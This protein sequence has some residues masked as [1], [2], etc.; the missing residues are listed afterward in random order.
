MTPRRPAVLTAIVTPFTGEGAID[1]PVFDQLLTMQSKGGVSGI[2]VAGT[3]GESPT[4]SVQEKLSLVRRA[5]ANLPSSVQVMAGSGGSS[6]EQSYE[7]SKLCLEAGADSL[8][9][10]T[11]PYNKPSVAGLLAHFGKIN[12]LGAPVCLYHVPGRTAQE[13][14]PAQLSSLCQLPNITMIKEAS[15]DLGLFSRAVASCDASLFSGDD[16]TY[17]PSLAVGGKGV[18]SVVSNIFPQAMVALGQAFVDGDSARSQRINHILLPFMDMM[19]CESNPGP[20]KAVLASRFGFHN[21]LRLPLVAVSSENQEPII[22][23]YNSTQ[24]A[25][26]E[27]G[28]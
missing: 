9:V 20:V 2:V 19:F 22:S 14:T 3:T 28:L 13:L 11:P 1:W 25:L 23:L 18:I 7:L 17:L 27:M 15:A 26:M 12:D 6:T 24:A 4:L 21:H 5:R 10:V 16:A 8:L